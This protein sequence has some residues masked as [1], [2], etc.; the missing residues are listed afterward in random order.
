MTSVSVNGEAR[1]VPE[2][3]S[4]AGL[5]RD[6]GFDVTRIAVEIDGSICPKARLP[7]VELVDGNRLEVVSF[8]GG[9]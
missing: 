7:D 4:V 9:G 2:G 5:L 1:D 6:M 8:V 3:T